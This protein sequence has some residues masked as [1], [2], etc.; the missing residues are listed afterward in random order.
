MMIMMMMMTVITSL[1]IIMMM[2]DDDDHRG[3]QGMNVCSCWCY[4]SLTC[5]VCGAMDG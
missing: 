3:S 1:M 5:R 4:K 2:S